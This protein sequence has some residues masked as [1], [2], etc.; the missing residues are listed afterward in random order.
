M[1]SK[2]VVLSLIP[3]GS[4]SGNLSPLLFYC[5]FKPSLIY[6]GGLKSIKLALLFPYEL[7]YYSSLTSSSPIIFLIIDLFS[8]SPSCN[9]SSKFKKT[10]PISFYSYMGI[11]LPLSSTILSRTL[12]GLQ[13]F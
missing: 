5:L 8:P 6:L 2:A 7:P 10:S 9:L 4:I 3:S 13:Y 12:V 11:L 1:R